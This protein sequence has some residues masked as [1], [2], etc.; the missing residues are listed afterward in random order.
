MKTHEKE[1]EEAL[2]YADQTGGDTWHNFKVLAIEIEILK[3]K[4]H[5]MRMQELMD[6]NRDEYE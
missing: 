2:E 3:N 6:I 4:I 1:L 5:S